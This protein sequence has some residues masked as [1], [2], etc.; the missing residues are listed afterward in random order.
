MAPNYA[1]EKSGEIPDIVPKL[2]RLKCVVVGD[3]AIGKTSLLVSYTT[4]GYPDK[5]IPTVHDYYTVRITVGNRPIMFQLFDTAGQEQFE[6]IRRL[7]YSSASIFLICFNVVDPDS[8][9]NVKEKWIHE[10]KSNSRKTPFLLV[11]TQS[12]QRSSVDIKLK[13]NK[14]GKK[15][16]TVEEAEHF[17][18][19][20]GAKKYIE[21]S[22]LTQKNLKYLF[23]TAI[24]TVLDNR[25]KIAKKVSK[26][27]NSILR[28]SLRR[29]SRKN[30]Q[31]RC[32]I[33]ET[34][35]SEISSL[36]SDS[37]ISKYVNNNL[38]NVSTQTKSKNLRNLF[39][40]G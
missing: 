10:V 33:G 28:S 34:I 12:D 39:C 9:L 13:L 14:E 6:A 27:S 25:E 24:L 22:A 19:K 23:D 29:L 30:S 32:S 40:L 38:D 16:V 36:N 1:L 3:G 17:A 31:K 7:S 2:D 11:G 37:T 8:F 21:C 35:S 4:N 18:K 20:I 26:N 5:Y 15:P